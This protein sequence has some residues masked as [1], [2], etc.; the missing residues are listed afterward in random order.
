MGDFQYDDG[1]GQTIDY[2]IVTFGDEIA[3]LY[4]GSVRNDSS[5]LITYPFSAN[6]L[7]FD[8]FATHVA[9]KKPQN[10]EPDVFEYSGSPAVRPPDFT[11][12]S[13]GIR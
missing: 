4:D 13:L 10:A 3:R 9:N 11:E 6:K 2:E 7:L 12:F 5:D 1:R 8:D